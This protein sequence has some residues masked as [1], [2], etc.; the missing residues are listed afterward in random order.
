[1]KRYQQT[2]N[3]ITDA[4]GKIFSERSEPEIALLRTYD[5]V[6]FG[7]QMKLVKNQDPSDSGL[8][9]YYVPLDE[10]FEIIQENH[11]SMGHRSIRITLKEI[12]KSFVNITKKQVK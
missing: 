10:V 9:K 8:S 1:M 7:T 2:I 11:L 6:N 4:K 5:I 12:K 3:L